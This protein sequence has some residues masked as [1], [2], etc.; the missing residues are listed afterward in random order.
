MKKVDRILNI[1]D[2][3]LARSI[4]AT[5]RA[6][7]LKAKWTREDVAE[8]VGLSPEVYARLERGNMLPRVPTLQRLCA[9]LGVEAD[10]ACGLAEGPRR[11]LPAIRPQPQEIAE[12]RGVVR[13]LRTLNDEALA[14]FT[15]VL[16]VLARR[17]KRRT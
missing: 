16:S 3:Q 15:E 13:K 6:A 10:V 5:A 9:V 14:D 1:T 11:T 17:R 2:K 12:V 7:R 4:G 8:F